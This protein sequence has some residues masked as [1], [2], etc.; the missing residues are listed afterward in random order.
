MQ[1]IIGQL[2]KIVTDYEPQLRKLSEAD[3]SLKPAPEKWSGKELVGH[4]ID[5]AQSNIRR[6]VIA[7]YEER[8]HIVYA[9][10][11]WVI[12]ADYQNYPV[13]DLIDL[14][15][16]L[17]RHIIMILKN[18]PEEAHSREVQTGDIHTIKWLASDYNKHMLH[19]LHQALKLDPVPYP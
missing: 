1:A 2:R 13:K 14:W 3:I 8:P 9:Q 11:E 18:M 6:F 19:H 17:N 7:Q 4:L 16:L 5:S 12:A 15:V 10:N